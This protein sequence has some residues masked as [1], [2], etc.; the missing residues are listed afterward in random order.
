MLHDIFLF[1]NN[2]ILTSKYKKVSRTDTFPFPLHTSLPRPWW[3]GSKALVTPIVQLTSLLRP[4]A[5][6]VEDLLR[7]GDYQ[8]VGLRVPDERV[9]GFPGLL[10]KVRE[11]VEGNLFPAGVLDPLAP[12]VLDGVHSEGTVLVPEHL[13]T[14]SE[15]SHQF[16]S[17]SAT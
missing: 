12:V 13:G 5:Q 16:E 17:L 2:L 15:S 11:V 14:D 1:Q 9:S 3:T 4:V 8:P 7:A 10:V 6:D